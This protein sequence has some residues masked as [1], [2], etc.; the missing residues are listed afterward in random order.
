M[1]VKGSII[2]GIVT[3]LVLLI[4]SIIYLLIEKKKSKD[5]R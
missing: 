3:N 1:T 5:G 4:G 2:T